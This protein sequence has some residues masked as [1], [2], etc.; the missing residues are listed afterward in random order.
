MKEEKTTQ[1]RTTVKRTYS[2]EDLKKMLKLP[3]GASLFVM[4][5]GGGDWS[6]TQ[7]EIGRETELQSTW[8]KEET[9]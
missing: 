2:V 3:A 4:V 6:S 7:L 8:T 9:K 1:V 5:P